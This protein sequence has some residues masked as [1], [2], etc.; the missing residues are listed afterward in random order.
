MEESD[1]KIFKQIK[2]GD[3]AAFE[4]LFKTH[5]ADLCH[6]ANSYLKD[7]DEAEEMVQEAF[8]R[9]WQKRKQILIQKNLKGYL[10]RSVRNM[11]TEYGRHLKV[12]QH[13]AQ[14]RPTGNLNLSP[15][16]L[17]EATQLE[18]LFH[19]TLLSL[20]ERCRTIFSMSREEGLKYKEIA[21]KLSISVKTVE[22]DMG[23]T[24]KALREAIKT[25]QK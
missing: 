7:P 19:Q 23:S 15:H 20:P 24:L 10:Y 11:C 4:K 25:T 3:K 17:L 2:R 13:Y 6:F 8:F 21:Q 12:K 5:Y 18:T 9:L 16:D 22:A 14:N 1:K